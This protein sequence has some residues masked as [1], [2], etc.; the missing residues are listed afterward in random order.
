VKQISSPIFRV[1]TTVVFFLLAIAPLFAQTE[2]PRKIT[3]TQFPFAIVKFNDDAPKSWN[4]YKSDRK[5]F[6]LLRL[7]KRYLL[8]NVSDEEVYDLDPKT[9]MV[10]G[11]TVDW[12]FS[13][14]PKKTLE[15]PD[16][17]ERNIGGLQRVRFRLGKDGHFIEL[18]LP[19]DVNGRPSY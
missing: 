18:Q 8:L 3:W 15:T 7:W 17:K 6:L 9:L 5:G 19:Y 2:A 1:I 13:D 12:S 11:N 14:L 4:L 10:N 16:W